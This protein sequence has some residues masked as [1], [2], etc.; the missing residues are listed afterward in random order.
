M[1]DYELGPD[2]LVMWLVVALS[3]F[4]LIEVMW[5]CCQ[6]CSWFSRKSSNT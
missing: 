5:L 1:L 2:V 6:F 4:R 3:Y